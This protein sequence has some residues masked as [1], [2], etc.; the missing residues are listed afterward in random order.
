MSG[1][2]SRHGGDYT[3]HSG[4]VND[5]SLGGMQDPNAIPS[6]FYEDASQTDIYAAA[7]N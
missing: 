4:F 6:L 1:N 7:N 5:T 2:G 3:T